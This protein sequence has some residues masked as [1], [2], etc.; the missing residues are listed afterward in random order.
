MPTIVMGKRGTVVI[1]A[2]LRKDLRLEEGT[3]IEV[4]KREGGLYLRPVA[5]APEIEIYTPE[6]LAEFFLNNAMDREDYL[7]AR[8]EVQAMGIDPDTIDHYRWPAV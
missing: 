3:A 1:P 6:R 5:A 8:K 7:E 2:A 4:E